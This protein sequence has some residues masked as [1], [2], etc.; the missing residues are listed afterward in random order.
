[1]VTKSPRSFNLIRQVPSRIKRQPRSREA[2]RP[3]AADAWAEIW[4]VLEIHVT[5]PGEPGLAKASLC[6][7]LIAHNQAEIR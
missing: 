3:S 4:R 5:A 7:G 6:R 1:M 2:P